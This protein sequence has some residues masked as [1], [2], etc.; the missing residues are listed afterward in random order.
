MARWI[1]DPQYREEVD[2]VSSELKLPVYKASAKGK[3][4]QWFKESWNKIEDYLLN[5]KQAVD[6]KEPKI[7][8]KTGFNLNKTDDYDQQDSNKLATGMA[9]YRLWQAMKVMTGSIELTWDAIRNKP[10]KFPPENH[11]HDNRYSRSD[12]THDERYAGKAHAHDD[13]YYTETETD[14][15]IEGLAGK[16]DGTFPLRRAEKGKVY[17]LEST[18]KYY[19]C[20]ES[21]DSYQISAPNSNFIEMSVYENL[22]RLN[23]LDKKTSIKEIK[24][25][26]VTGHNSYV[27]IPEDFQFAIVY[28]SIGYRNE[29]FSAIFVKGFT[30]KLSYYAEHKEIVLQ[31]QGNKIYLSDKGEEWDANIEKI[32][33]M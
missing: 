14:K 16:K 8:K 3:F 17:L 28:F 18:G 6:S 12:H 11:N 31:L 26:R 2:E 10:A 30:T 32:Y 27:E 9:L 7:H 19:F 13:R 15:K 5:L 4:R 29:V 22:N 21:Y 1:Q 33:Y 20:K 24:N 23:N 25:S